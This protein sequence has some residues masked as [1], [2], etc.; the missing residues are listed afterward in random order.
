MDFDKTQYK[1]DSTGSLR[2]ISLIKEID[3]V[4]DDVVME[5]V[6][7][8]EDLNKV[9]TDFKVNSMADIQA[10]IDLSAEKYDVK[11]GGTKGNVTLLSYDG[12]YKVTRAINDYI[13]FDERLQVA[14]QLID[15]CIKRWSGEGMNEYLKVIVDDAFQVDKT[16]NISV[17]RILGLRRHD[18][19][20]PQWIKAMEAISD[21]ITVT[22]SKAYIRIYKRDTDGKYSQ[23]NLDLAAI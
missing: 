17:E 11:I 13:V 19:K 4:R 1:E 7:K 22:G 8:S 3:L 12:K 15:E 18:I 6:K 5:I 9:L 16:G 14:K 23:I 2:P 21:S 20:D 10:F